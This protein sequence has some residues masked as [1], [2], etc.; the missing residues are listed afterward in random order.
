MEMF[1]NMG[2]GFTCHVISLVRRLL[3]NFISNF[4]TILVLLHL[5]PFGLQ[6]AV[7]SPMSPR[8]QMFRSYTS[9]QVN[10][11][12]F[13]NTRISSDLLAIEFPMTADVKIIG[14]NIFVKCFEIIEIRAN[15]VRL[16]NLKIGIE[17]HILNFDFFIALLRVY[18]FLARHLLKFHFFIYNFL[19]SSCFQTNLM[20]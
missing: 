11:G 3:N 6:L 17:V 2:S 16:H 4:L 15:L 7:V 9:Y 8:R 13:G 1:K 14:P 20:L 12:Y 19:I 10:S 5:L 18:N